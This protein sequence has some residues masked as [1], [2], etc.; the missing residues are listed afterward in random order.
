MGSERKRQIFFCS[1]SSTIFSQAPCVSVAATR[2]FVSAVML[3][4]VFFL[5]C[6]RGLG[7]LL[8]SVLLSLQPLLGA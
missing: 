1:A 7:C 6:G 3:I 2:T 4:I 8:L 5:L